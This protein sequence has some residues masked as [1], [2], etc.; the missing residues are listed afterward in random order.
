LKLLVRPFV[1]QT[2]WFGSAVLAVF[3]LSL[4]ALVRYISL[5]RLREQMQ[6]VQQRAALDGERARIARDM[7]DTVGASLTQIGLLGELANR[8]A[9]PPEQ[10]S[11]YVRKMTEGSHAL[12]QQLDEIVWAVDPEND[13]LEDLAA[14]VSQFVEEFFADSPIRCRMKAPAMLPELRLTTDVRHNLFLAVREALNNVARHSRAT[15][16]SVQL[17]AEDGAVVLRIEDNGRGF[18]VRTVTARHGLENLRRR[19]SEIGGTCRIESTEGSGT[20]IVLVWPC[21][22]QRPLI[23]GNKTTA[24]I[25]N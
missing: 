13:T 18:D 11:D 1:W 17:A 22:N 16:A 4:V 2:W 12:V 15:E 10:A 3:T 5:R 25:P 14:Y 8:P 20:K 9:T 21:R 24:D 7:H 6:Q 23:P 19:L